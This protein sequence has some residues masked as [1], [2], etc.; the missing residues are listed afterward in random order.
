MSL[1]PIGGSDLTMFHTCLSAWERR[2]TLVRIP[3][4]N[5]VPPERTAASLSSKKLSNPRTV[6]QSDTT[7]SP[8]RLARAAQECCR[9]KA[10]FKRSFERTKPGKD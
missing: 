2:T 8:T 10:A 9:R 7:L 4:V 5:K 6:P 3:A 1:I